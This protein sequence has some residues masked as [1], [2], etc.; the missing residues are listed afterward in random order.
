MKD[1]C[2]SAVEGEKWEYPFAQLEAA[3]L[4]PAFA[5]AFTDWHYRCSPGYRFQKLKRRPRLVLPPIALSQ[6]KRIGFRK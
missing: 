1:S 3:N 6:I 5:Q 2:E 4:G